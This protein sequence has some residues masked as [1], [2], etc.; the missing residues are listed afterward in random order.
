MINSVGNVVLKAVVKVVDFVVV[1]DEG[2]WVDVV[3]TLADNFVVVD[4]K[5]LNV[6]FGSNTFVIGEM[7]VEGVLF[8]MVVMGGVVMVVVVLYPN[9]GVVL[10]DLLNKNPVGLVGFKIVLSR[11]RVILG[12]RLA[13]LFSFILNLLGWW[14]CCLN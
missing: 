6:D 10:D 1:V 4:A 5:L 2:C 8:F 3:V 11:T 14:E 7:V 9:V 12:L 13:C